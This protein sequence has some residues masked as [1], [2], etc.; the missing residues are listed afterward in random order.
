MLKTKAFF[1]SGV[2]KRRQTQSRQNNAIAPPAYVR[3]QVI[4]HFYKSTI[5]DVI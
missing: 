2:K 1:F 5:T 3:T 4:S